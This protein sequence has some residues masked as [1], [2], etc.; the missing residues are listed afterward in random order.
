VSFMSPGAPAGHTKLTGKAF[1]LNGCDT[2]L[3]RTF[4]SRSFT[5][6]ISHPPNHDH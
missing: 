4:A 2:G 6:T 3:P 1:L 5:I